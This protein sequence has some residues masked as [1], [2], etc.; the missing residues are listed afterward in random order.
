MF[1]RLNSN[2]LWKWSVA[3]RCW[4]AVSIGYPALTHAYYASLPS[5]VVALKYRVDTVAFRDAYLLLGQL[6]WWTPLLVLADHQRCHAA[7]P[8]V[9]RRG[10]PAY[11]IAGHPSRRPVYVRWAEGAATGIAAKWSGALASGQPIGEEVRSC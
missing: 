4:V 11:G 5:A 8:A 10:M 3:V 1:T 7:G 9:V 2:R 6:R